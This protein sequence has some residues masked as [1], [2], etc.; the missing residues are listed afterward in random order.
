MNDIDGLFRKFHEWF[1]GV[2][3]LILVPFLKNSFVR[4]ILQTTLQKILSQCKQMRYDVS[5]RTFVIFRAYQFHENFIIRMNALSNV[6]QT[7][8]MALF[9]TNHCEEARISMEAHPKLK[10]PES[11][12]SSSIAQA[13][14]RIAQ[15]RGMAVHADQGQH[16]NMKAFAR[17][18]GASPAA[19]A[20]LGLPL[21]GSVSVFMAQT[22]PEVIPARDNLMYHIDSLS[23]DTNIDPHEVYGLMFCASDMVNLPTSI[24]T[25]AAT[26]S[27]VTL[28]N[29]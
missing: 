28:F 26:P 1:K 23:V 17:A 14:K 5:L 6:M 16:A 21:V 12:P 27:S 15:V 20:N 9:Y 22:Q 2:Q 18:S 10:L 29:K 11:P 8:L 19:A 25:S 3:F 24:V 13:Y 4:H 7:E